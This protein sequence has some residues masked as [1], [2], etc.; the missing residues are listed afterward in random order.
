MDET[1]LARGRQL[2]KPGNGH[3]EVHYAIFSTSVYV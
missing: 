2:L 1:T 3:K